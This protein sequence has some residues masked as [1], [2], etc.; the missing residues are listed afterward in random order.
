VKPAA[1]TE[2][3]RAAPASNSARK[4]LSYIEQREWDS[5]EEKILEAEVEAAACQRELQEA[6]SDRIRLV[7]TYER[8]QRAQ[9]RVEKLYERWAEL[10]SK[11]AQ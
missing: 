3:P 1:A 10:E 9:E 7:E 5:I 4:K 8:F 11:V 2:S 6:A